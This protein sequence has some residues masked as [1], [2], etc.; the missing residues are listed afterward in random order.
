MA[1][2]R[3]KSHEELSSYLHNDF[4]PVLFEHYPPLRELYARMKALGI[5]RPLLSGSGPAMLGFIDATPQNRKRVATWF[6]NSIVQPL[7]V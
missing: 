3:A 1:L 7:A 2:R 6:T 4:E 5:Q